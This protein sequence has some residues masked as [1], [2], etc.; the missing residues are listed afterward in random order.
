MR[1]RQA[2]QGG[3]PDHPFHAHI[4]T[5]DPH[6]TCYVSFVKIGDRPGTELQTNFF[7]VTLLE[8]IVELKVQPPDSIPQAFDFDRGDIRF[9]MEIIPQHPMTLYLAVAALEIMY[10]IVLESEVRESQALVVCQDIAM[11]RFRTWFS[12][13]VMESVVLQSNGTSPEKRWRS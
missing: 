8:Q 7:I 9:K 13:S 3:W 5:P 2:W 6:E 11:G 10:G 12:D 4:P 1:F